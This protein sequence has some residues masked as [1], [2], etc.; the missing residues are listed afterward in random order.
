MTAAQIGRECVAHLPQHLLVAGHHG[1]AFREGLG[2]LPSLPV[3]SCR[4]LWFPKRWGLCCSA[5]CA[6]HD[7]I[8]R[9]YHA[10]TANALIVE[11]ISSAPKSFPGVF[12]WYALNARGR[13]STGDLLIVDTEDLQPIPPFEIH[14]KRLKPKEVKTISTESMNVY[15]RAGRAKSCKRDSRHLPLVQSGE[16]PH[17][18]ISARFIRRNIRSPRCRSRY[19]SLTRFLEHC[20]RYI[21]RNHVA[22]TTKLCVPDDDFPMPLI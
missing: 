21:F 19:R 14:V 5:P 7:V 11:C 4:D 17:A 9:A 12:I 18:R 2:F 20:W 8:T 6:Q 16:R 10:R 22:P 3:A 1:S 13:S 15:S